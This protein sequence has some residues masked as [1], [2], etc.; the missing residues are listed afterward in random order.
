MKTTRLSGSR[1]LIKFKSPLLLLAFFTMVVSYTQE[2]NNSMD[3][4][5]EESKAMF[6]KMK[7]LVGKWKGTFKWTGV[8]TGG[9]DIGAEYYLTGFG[10]SLIENLF[11]GDGTVSMTSVYHL[12]WDDLRM[13]H[14]CGA[15]NHP[16]LK[17]AE[18]DVSV[19]TVSFEFI[20]ITNFTNE[21]I[22]HVNGVSLEFPEPDLLNIVFNFTSSKGEST[23]YIT[24]KR[25]KE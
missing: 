9:G 4:V 13:T 24:M 25:V 11:T 10:S 23:E 18:M 8:R 22:G 6:T 16:R 20:D 2:G 17:A 1:R 12:D 5:E 19:N 15:N 21:G 3:P 14:F 7:S